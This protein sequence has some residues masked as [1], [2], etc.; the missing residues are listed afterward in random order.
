MASELVLSVTLRCETD[1]D[2]RSRESGKLMQDA[3]TCVVALG[4]GLLVL[5]VAPLGGGQVK[6]GEFPQAAEWHGN[7]AHEAVTSPAD[8]LEPKHIKKFSPE[9]R[10]SSDR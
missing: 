4:F 8:P 1:Q 3:S 6:A 9:R 5:L 10:R 2:G 7:I